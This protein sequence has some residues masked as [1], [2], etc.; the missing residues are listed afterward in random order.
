MAL[1]SARSVNYRRFKIFLNT[2][3]SHVVNI[4]E[5]TVLPHI[6]QEAMTPDLCTL[7]MNFMVHIIPQLPYEPL[8]R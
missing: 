1:I 4:L 6:L 2:E 7:N 5:L 8:K 3:F